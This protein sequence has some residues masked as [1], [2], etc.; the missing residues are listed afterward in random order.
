MNFEQVPG[1][2]DFAGVYDEMVARARTGAVFVEIGAYLGRSTAYLASRIQQ[3]GKRIRLV[4]VDLWDGWFYNDF[5]QHSPMPEAEGAYYR[6]LANMRA[7][8]VENVLYPIKL[9]SAQAATLF[10]DDSVD[11]VW[12][13]GDHGYE[14]VRHD[15]EA[16][17]PRI[18]PGGFLGGHDYNNDDF[19]GVRQAV[20][21][22]FAEVGLE[23]RDGEGPAGGWFL[24]QK[25][26]PGWLGQ[27]LRLSKEVF[28][29]LMS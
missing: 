16:W 12:L 2:F 29:S 17:F 15:L 26:R 8:R 21:P 5:R 7:C 3:S 19:P 11:F 14:G 27:A 25:P 1:W 24:A 23:L 20:D 4:V 22:F 13:D 10:D 9:P 28:A 18:R 6:F